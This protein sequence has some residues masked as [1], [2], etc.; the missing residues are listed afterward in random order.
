M[1]AQSPWHPM[2]TCCYLLAVSCHNTFGP[3]TVCTDRFH[4]GYVDSVTFVSGT[5]ANQCWKQITIAKNIGVNEERNIVACHQTSAHILASGLSIAATKWGVSL[6][7]WTMGCSVRMIETTSHWSHSAM[8]SWMAHF[9]GNQMRSVVA[10]LAVATAVVPTL[11][12]IR[13]LR[14]LAAA[15]NRW[16]DSHAPLHVHQASKQTSWLYQ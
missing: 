2:V 13:W 1:C 16:Q 10:Q 6:L 3:A 4:P 14:Q 12:W 7:T 11:G 9:W 5:L 8:T 15:E